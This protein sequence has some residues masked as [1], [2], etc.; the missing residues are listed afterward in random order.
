MAS[1]LLD[2]PLDKLRPLRPQRYIGPG[3]KLY[4]YGMP[5]ADRIDRNE[6][7]QEQES[8]EE[9]THAAAAASTAAASSSS[10]AAASSMH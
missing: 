6:M 1:Y 9:T 3:I 2:G 10:P 5:R 8:G 7:E 4:L